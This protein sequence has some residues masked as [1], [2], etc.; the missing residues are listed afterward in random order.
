LTVA[1]APRLAL[2]C[3]ICCTRPPHTPI[4]R[5][6]S[7][8]CEPVRTSSRRSSAP[9][10]ATRA[11]ARLPWL[12]P[13]DT[14]PRPGPLPKAAVSHLA[15]VKAALTGIRSAASPSQSS[16][17]KCA[18]AHKKE[19]KCSQ[20]LARLGLSS[21]P[22]R[23]LPPGRAGGCV[24]RR[25]GRGR[26]P[27]GAAMSYGE[28]QTMGGRIK[29]VSTRAWLGAAVGAPCASRSGLSVR[30]RARGTIEMHPPSQDKDGTARREAP[31][32]R[33]TPG[34]SLCRAL[35]AAA[36]LPLMLLLL[37]VAVPVGGND[38]HADRHF[39]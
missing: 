23:T 25:K 32:R 11:K 20:R 10:Q 29:T 12:S 39:A 13:S 26:G 3:P 16:R 5:S 17:G 35:A 22:E 8:Y 18:V 21:A 38:L 9:T 36:F 14:I 7:A 4:Y 33:S 1:R 24:D 19:E 31:A 27:A 15:A 34:Q 37:A 2:A 28:P 30:G 6:E